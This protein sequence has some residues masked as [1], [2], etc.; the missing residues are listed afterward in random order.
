MLYYSF[1]SF[2][3]NSFYLQFATD[4]SI[5]LLAM[6]VADMEGL[7]SVPQGFPSEDSMED[8]LLWLNR[9]SRRIV[10]RVSTKPNHAELREAVEGYEED[11]PA[12]QKKAKQKKKRFPF[13]FC[14]EG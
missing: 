13:C 14:K 6:E 3:S 8:Q 9:F 5:L 10:E 12:S 11:L 7:E 2:N 4:G 1:Q